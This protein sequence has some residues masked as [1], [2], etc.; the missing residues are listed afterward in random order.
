MLVLVFQCE[1]PFSAAVLCRV[2]GQ[3][4]ICLLPL[5]GARGFMAKGRAGA[6]CPDLGKTL[7]SS[8]DIDIILSTVSICWFTLFYPNTCA[9]ING[10]VWIGLS[11]GRSHS[12]VVRQL[13]VDMFASDPKEGRVIF[14]FLS[15]SLLQIQMLQLSC[16]AAAGVWSCTWVQCCLWAGRLR[17]WARWH[18]CLN[19]T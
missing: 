8:P 10:E 6:V 17:A 7:S 19:P 9:E 16:M 12:S 11:K 3:V 15:F 4:L 14:L 5:A 2:A 1:L 18:I 13:T